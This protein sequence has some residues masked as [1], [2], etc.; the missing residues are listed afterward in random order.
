MAFRKMDTPTA[1]RESSSNLSTDKEL[2]KEIEFKFFAPQAQN[3]TVSGTFN[4]WRENSMRLKKSKD[5]HWK[6]Q[7]K[8]SPGRYEYRFV[9]DGRWENDPAA[10]CVPNAFG[11]ANCILEVR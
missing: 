8:L 10:P 6:G 11:S 9:V 5:G 4:D 1:S 7:F 2:A 3:V